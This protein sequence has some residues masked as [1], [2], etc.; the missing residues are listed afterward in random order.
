MTTGTP[1]VTATFISLPSAKN[2][3][4]APSGDQNGCLAPSVPATAVASSESSDR[5]NKRDG[6]PPLMAVNAI[7]RPS[8]DTTG[9]E[10]SPVPAGSD[11]VNCVRFGP[12]DGGCARSRSHHPRTRRQNHRHARD[13]S[14]GPAS[15]RAQESAAALCRA[16]RFCSHLGRTDLLQRPQQIRR[17]LEPV[18]RCLGEQALHDRGQRAA[19]A[20]ANRADR[21]G[22]SHGGCRP[23]ARARTHAAPS[24]ARKESTPARTDPSADRPARP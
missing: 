14:D 16:R 13:P 19:R 24:S 23:Y 2:P 18:L 20:A 8:G 11:H 7:R 6:E 10:S 5:T 15:F 9:A 1:P 4:D 21:R 17:R 12:T 22:R 3:I